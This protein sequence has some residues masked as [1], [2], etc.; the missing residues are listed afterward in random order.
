MEKTI[1]SVQRNGLFYTFI[2]E[3]DTE[4]T[5][6]QDIYVNGLHAV[7]YNP[8][9]EIA[10]KMPVTDKTYSLFLRFLAAHLNRLPCKSHFDHVCPEI[11]A[12]KQNLPADL[13]DG[14]PQ[15]YVYYGSYYHAD[16]LYLKSVRRPNEY[17][18]RFWRRHGCKAVAHYEGLEHA[19]DIAFNDDG[20]PC[21]CITERR[22]GESWNI[23]CDE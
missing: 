14:I 5:D 8:E 13:K 9:K 7:R 12:I 15:Y 22:T 1:M 16:C 6:K 2:G 21:I 17:D 11:D 23:C 19:A 10:D 18:L 3:V 4:H 20:K